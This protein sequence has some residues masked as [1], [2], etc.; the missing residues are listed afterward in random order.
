MSKQHTNIEVTP[1]ELVNNLVLQLDT[2][3]E[4]DYFNIFEIDKVSGLLHLTESIDCGEKI[5][6]KPELIKKLH[7]KVREKSM[8]QIELNWKASEIINSL[9][10]NYHVSVP[11]KVKELLFSG[12]L[13]ELPLETLAKLCNN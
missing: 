13:I 4:Y 2:G 5:T 11:K 1:E 6:I 9:N 10:L 3:N 12:E 8:Y 7:Q